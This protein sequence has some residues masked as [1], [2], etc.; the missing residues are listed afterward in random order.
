MLFGPLFASS[1]HPTKFYTGQG[2]FSKS[3]FARSTIESVLSPHTYAKTTA[4]KMVLPCLRDLAT[5]GITDSQIRTD[6]EGHLQRM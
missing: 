3:T 4:D 2:P 5:R 6:Y 1:N